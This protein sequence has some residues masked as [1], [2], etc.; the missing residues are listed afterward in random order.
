MKASSQSLKRAVN[1]RRECNRKP[2]DTLFTGDPNRLRTY[3]SPANHHKYGI[4]IRLHITG[5]RQKKISTWS[6][7][8]TM[9]IFFTWQFQYICIL[10]CLIY[11]LQSWNIIRLH[12]SCLASFLNKRIEYIYAKPVGFILKQLHLLHTFPYFLTFGFPLP[13]NRYSK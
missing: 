6:A 13:C 8:N 7:Q 3:H 10:I 1:T 12:T 9:K 5:Y 11:V 4:N 2:F